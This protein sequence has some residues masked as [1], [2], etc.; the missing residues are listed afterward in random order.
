MQRLHNKNARKLT[1][2]SISCQ[3]MPNHKKVTKTAKQFLR[4]FGAP[5]RCFNPTGHAADPESKSDRCN[6][7][8]DCVEKV[9]II[10][11]LMHT[12]GAGC[13]NLAFVGSAAAKTLLSS[14]RL[15]KPCCRVGGCE[16]LIFVGAARAKT[17]FLS[18]RRLRKRYFCRVGGCAK[19]YFTHF[20]YISFSHTTSLTT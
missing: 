9:S 4:P 14:R 15:R 19:P 18:S 7:M 17:L 16:N 1:K 13:E 6:A 2:P 11:V 8:L 20:S 3:I 5:E 12:E 10:D